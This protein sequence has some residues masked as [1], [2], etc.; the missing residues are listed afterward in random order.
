MKEFQSYNGRAGRWVHFKDGK[1]KKQSETKIAGVPVKKGKPGGSKS[2]SSK[3][4]SAK[5]SGPGGRKLFGRFSL[6][7]WWK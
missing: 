3:K 4:T 7:D 1:I 5:Q 2:S 6:L